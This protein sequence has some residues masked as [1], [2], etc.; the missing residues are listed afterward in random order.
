MDNQDNQSLTESFSRLIVSDPI[1][2]IAD[3]AELGLDS[4]LDDGLLKDIPLLSTA[5]AVFKFGS[6][7]KYAHE[8]KKLARFVTSFNKN[9]MSRDDIHRYKETKFNNPQSIKH[10]L[11]YLLI[12]IEKYLEYEKPELLAKLYLEYLDSNFDWNT[13]C[14]YSVV[15]DNILLQDIALLREFKGKKGLRKGDIRDIA[16]ILRLASMGL[17]EI[18]TGQSTQSFGND[19]GVAFYVYEYD[20]T[21]TNFG[22][23]F[24]ENI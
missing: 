8:I 13:F 21:I 6:K 22:N 11:E 2:A 17:I 9:I 12:V 15:I 14:A 7:V 16:S 18:A 10:E 23:G 3:I 24:I 5:V 19:I 1:E 20:Y 4:I